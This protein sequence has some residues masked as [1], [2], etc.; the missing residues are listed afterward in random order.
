MS[1][2]P[3][4]RERIEWG[5]W[6]PAAPW[7]PAGV[8]LAASEE[9]AQVRAESTGPGARVVHRTVVTVTGRWETAGQDSLFDVEAS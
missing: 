4:R 6:H 3:G 7:C 2:Q 9:H 5:T 1:G 8:D